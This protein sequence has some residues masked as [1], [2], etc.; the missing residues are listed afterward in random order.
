MSF[1]LMASSVVPDADFVNAAAPSGHRRALHDV[2]ASRR[3]IQKIGY[4][5][6]GRLTAAPRQT[7]LRHIGLF[8]PAAR[9]SVLRAQPAGELLALRFIDLQPLNDLS[10]Y[11]S[12]ALTAMDSAMTRGAERSY[13]PGVI[14]STV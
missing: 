12:A 2:S 14:N 11:I 9:N 6:A 4:V 3:A 8:A 13:V 5:S 10:V 1:R 7:R